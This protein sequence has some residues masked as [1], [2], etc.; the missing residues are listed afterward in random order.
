MS[1]ISNEAVDTHFLHNHITPWDLLL[2]LSWHCL[3]ACVFWLRVLCNLFYIWNMRLIWFYY[4][5]Q[6][7]D[8]NLIQ[9]IKEFFSLKKKQL[10]QQ[11]SVTIYS[12]LYAPKTWNVIIEK[13]H[14]TNIICCKEKRSIGL[15]RMWCWRIRSFVVFLLMSCLAGK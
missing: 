10:W 6:Y 3:L 7:I 14:I 12:M 8:C 1:L 4:I 9:H 13:Y 2:V 5:T 15:K 11:F